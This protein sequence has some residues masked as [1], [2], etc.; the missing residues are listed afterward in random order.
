MYSVPRVDTPASMGYVANQ[1][2]DALF[3][4][5]LGL[6]Q[7]QMTQNR[8]QCCGQNEVYA[9]ALRASKNRACAPD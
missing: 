5:E 9:R 2:S 8:S 3:V 1:N 4:V 6:T 7:T